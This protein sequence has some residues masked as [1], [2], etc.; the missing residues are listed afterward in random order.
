MGDGVVL[1]RNRNSR[2]MTR[3]RLINRGSKSLRGK[4]AASCRTP[5]PHALTLFGTFR[6]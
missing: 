4:A 3:Q 2:P 1:N 5:A 6:E